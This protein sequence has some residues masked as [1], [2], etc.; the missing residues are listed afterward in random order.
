MKA[1]LE[2]NL[3]ED[4]EEYED[5]INGV[6]YKMALDAV[7]EKIFRPRHKHGYDNPTINEL[8]LSP[9]ADTLMDELE[10]IYHQIT[11]DGGYY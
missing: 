7:W 5:A 3:P 2:F 4:Q 11:T 9:T 1:T 6:K 10:K 8:M